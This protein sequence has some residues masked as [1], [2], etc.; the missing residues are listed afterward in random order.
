VL[1]HG[2]IVESGRHQ[3]LILAGGRYTTL[4]TR[5]AELAPAPPVLSEVP[6]A[7]AAAP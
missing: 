3:D 7:G 6:E 5:D 4:A 2:R 1:D